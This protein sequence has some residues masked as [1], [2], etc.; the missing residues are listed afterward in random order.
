[1]DNMMAEFEELGEK[2]DYNEVVTNITYVLYFIKLFNFFIFIRQSTMWCASSCHEISCISPSSKSATSSQSGSPHT[3]ADSAQ[4]S[5]NHFPS[6]HD[7]VLIY[8]P[9]VF[10]SHSIFILFPR[11]NL[12]EFDYLNFG[13]QY[14]IFQKL[15]AVYDMEPDNFPRF[16]QRTLLTLFW[17]A[18]QTTLSPVVY[19]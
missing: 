17:I 3:G 12:S 14:Q 1:M 15:L 9:I 5:S 11:P 7:I 4:M 19:S 18:T 6:L 10:E 2:E 16:N 13:K 8:Q